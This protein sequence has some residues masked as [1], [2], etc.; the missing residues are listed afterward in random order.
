MGYDVEIFGID[1]DNERLIPIEDF[2][3]VIVN[4]SQ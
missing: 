3:K 4:C 2:A 1:F